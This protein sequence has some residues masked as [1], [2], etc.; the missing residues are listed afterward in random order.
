MLR[1]P[2]VVGRSIVLVWSSQPSETIVPISSVLASSSIAPPAQS[3][4]S[5]G[6]STS[7]CPTSSSSSTSMISST[8]MI[9]SLTPSIA[10]T[11]ATSNASSPSIGTIAAISVVG[12]V[13][14]ASGLIVALLRLRRRYYP[15][16]L[17]SDNEQNSRVQSGWVD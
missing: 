17:R 15:R 8:T 13:I 11:P 12:G 3:P 4:I 9:S 5:T 16:A 10:S 1:A 14:F 7:W 6:I 2:I